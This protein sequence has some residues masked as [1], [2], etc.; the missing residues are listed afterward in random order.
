MLEQGMSSAVLLWPSQARSWGAS[1]HSWYSRCGASSGGPVKVASMVMR[2]RKKLALEVFV[3]AVVVFD[4]LGYEANHLPILQFF[5]M[6]VGAML[7]IE[8]GGRILGWLSKRVHLARRLKF[9]SS[10]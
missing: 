8:V 2:L 4:I 1:R 7:E 6:W 9:R 3:S 5:P 10:R